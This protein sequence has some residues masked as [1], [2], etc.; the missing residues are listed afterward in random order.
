MRNAVQGS[1]FSVRFDASIRSGIVRSAGIRPDAT[2]VATSK[3]NARVRILRSLP[4]VMGGRS[5]HGARPA[6]T[7]PKCAE[8]A[9]KEAKIHSL[10]ALLARTL[11]IIRNSPFEIVL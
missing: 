3:A 11:F 7:R 10:F 1:S 8:S 9:V 6:E 2:D 5:L 4:L